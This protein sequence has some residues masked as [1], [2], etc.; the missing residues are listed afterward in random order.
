MSPCIPVNVFASTFSCTYANN[1]SHKSFD[2]GGHALLISP[3]GK[4]RHLKMHLHL[5]FHSAISQYILEGTPCHDS[6][7]REALKFNT[8]CVFSSCKDILRK[9]IANR[10]CKR[11][12]SLRKN[13]KFLCID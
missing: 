12:L 4:K 7:K 11:S 2:E 3:R 8:N 13:N 9:R 1:A 5:R 10:T 6:P